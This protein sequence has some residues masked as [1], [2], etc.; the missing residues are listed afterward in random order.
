MVFVILA[1]MAFL[2]ASTPAF[3]C[4]AQFDPS[5]A[6]RVV[7]PTAAPVASGASP[8]PA[9]TAPAPGFVQADMGHIHVALGSQVTYA[10]CPPA[11]GKHYQSPGGP[12]R[13]GLYGPND[14]AI[15]QGWV[16]NLEHEIGR[17]SCRERV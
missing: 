3:A 7:T 5:P 6:P 14:A 16:H 8:A 9:V 13:G 10:N 12:I 4:T 2:N 1:S 11:S 17:A 15:P